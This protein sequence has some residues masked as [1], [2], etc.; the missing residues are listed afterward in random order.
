MALC[1]WSADDCR[2]D[3]YAYREADGTYV[4]HVAA[5]R[6][7][8][9]IPAIDHGLLVRGDVDAWMRQFRAQ[10]DAMRKATRIPIGGPYDGQTI[11]SETARD[12]MALLHKL[13]G[14][15]YQFPDWVFGAVHD[16]IVADELEAHQRER[17]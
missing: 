14:A 13:R 16:E 3:L 17:T 1:R 9:P 6:Y 15:G 2:C 7:G 10:L 4:T 11:R 12:L 8:E 5:F